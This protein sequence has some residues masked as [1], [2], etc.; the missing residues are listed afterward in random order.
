M[1]ALLYSII[2]LWRVF[3][4]LS[5]HSFVALVDGIMMRVALP[6]LAM[7]EEHLHVI[8]HM[9]RSLRAGAEPVV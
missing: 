7:L 2:Y 8:W 5:S 1:L 6:C 4:I 3:G 9:E